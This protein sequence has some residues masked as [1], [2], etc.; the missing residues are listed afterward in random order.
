MFPTR[1]TGQQ[2]VSGAYRGTDFNIDFPG[3]KPFVNFGFFYR[4]RLRCLERFSAGASYIL[5]L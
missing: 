2:C 1:W 3:L 4:S 5:E